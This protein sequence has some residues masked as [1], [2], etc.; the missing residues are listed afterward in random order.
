MM[1]PMTRKARLT[2]FRSGTFRPWPNQTRST[3]SS[4][5]RTRDIPD[6]SPSSMPMI[7]ARKE[8]IIPLR[9]TPNL[10]QPIRSK[11]PQ[12]FPRRQQTNR[13]SPS[14]MTP[15]GRG[16]LT[17]PLLSPPQHLWP[18]HPSAALTKP[19]RF[20]P[21]QDRT[22]RPFPSPMTPRGRGKR[23]GPARARPAP[24]DPGQPWSNRLDSLRR[25][26]NRPNP[27]P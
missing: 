27:N 5:L 21:P 11:P 23:S 18:G 1:L 6:Q 16:N 3:P 8:A 19:S 15:R 14:P 4:T 10:S 9:A 20:S 22:N 25:P 2:R 13:P 7:S 17:V 24:P 12:S 26:T